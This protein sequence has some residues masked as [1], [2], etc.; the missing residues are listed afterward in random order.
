MSNRIFI[1]G[2]V[3][4]SLELK[5]LSN[6]NFP[7]AK[8]LDCNDIVIITGD[9]GF[10]W[11]NSKE[12][13]YWDDW[14]ENRPFT[15]VCCYG[16]HENYSRIRELSIEQWHNSIIRKVRPHVMYIENGEILTINNKKF[17]FMGGA[18]SIDKAYRIEGKKLV[19][20]RNSVNF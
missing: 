8:N 15:T 4:G 14:I 20:R 10:M 11:D 1:T 12:T 18:A 17:F 13:K 7:L 6:K 19:G 3:H 2:D 5:R 16:N 9:C